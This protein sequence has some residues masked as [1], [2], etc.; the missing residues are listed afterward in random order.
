[1]VTAWSGNFA[2]KSGEYWAA[3]SRRRDG[4]E[5]ADALTEEKEDTLSAGQVGAFVLL[6]PFAIVGGALFGVGKLLEYAFYRGPKFLID[7]IT[8]K[9]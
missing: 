4:E 3:E 7:G 1:M 2:G 9:E 8:C 6:S 5:G